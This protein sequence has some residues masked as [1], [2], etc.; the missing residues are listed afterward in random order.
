MFAVQLSVLEILWNS[1][2]IQHWTADC[3]VCDA[4]VVCTSGLED[5]KKQQYTTI[6]RRGIE[7]RNYVIR[8]AWKGGI[9]AT[10]CLARR[11]MLCLV[12]LSFTNLRPNSEHGPVQWH[13]VHFIC[14]DSSELFRPVQS[15][16]INSTS[17]VCS[18]QLHREADPRMASPALKL[19]QVLQVKSLCL[20][21]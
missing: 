8:E 17:A 1:D 21:H 4:F 16:T 9:S 3:Q 2:N 6:K 12:C 11:V 14:L 13:S 5:I 20:H 19:L 7:I 18:T 15:V 10:Y